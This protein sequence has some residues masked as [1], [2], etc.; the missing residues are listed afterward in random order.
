MIPTQ[1]PSPLLNRFAGDRERAD[2]IKLPWCS[3]RRRWPERRAEAGPKGPG[4]RR[5]GDHLSN[6]PGCLLSG[7]RGVPS[8]SSWRQQ[9]LV[10]DL[11]RGPCRGGACDPRKSHRKGSAAG[12]RRL[13]S[14]T[15]G[16]EQCV[17]NSNCLSAIID[18]DVSPDYRLPG[19]KK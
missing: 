1:R 7:D 9:G 14:E 8:T 18:R 12:T 16:L 2:Q 19:Y 15:A 4:D 5:R 10:C 13:V 3:P 17:P 6:R 11:W